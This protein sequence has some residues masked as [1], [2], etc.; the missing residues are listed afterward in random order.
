MPDI[1]NLVE[2]S[3]SQ[4]QLI[5]QKLDCIGNGFNHTNWSD[6]DFLDI[7]K[8]IR[9]FYRNEQKSICSYC[10]KDTS[11]QAASN[12]H[13]EH[14]VPKSKYV[15]F[16]FEPKNLCVICADCNVIKREQET[17]ESIEDTVTGKTRRKQYPRASSS[18]KIIHPHFDN[19]NE[20]ILIENGWYIDKSDKGY[21]TIGACKLNRRLREFGWEEIFYTESEL[22]DLMTKYINSTNIIEKFDILKVFKR[23]S[24]RLG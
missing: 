3:E 22:V 12:C 11:M 10:K 21:F 14:I 2:Y 18:F 8:T 23:I 19:Y 24:Y 9:D 5:K 15:S 20:H 7:R 13:V 6:D 4:E 1:N 17:C 16:I